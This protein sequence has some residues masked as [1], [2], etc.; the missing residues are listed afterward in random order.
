MITRDDII[1]VAEFLS[2]GLTESVI[3]EALH[4]LHEHESVYEVEDK[5]T[6][7]EKVLYSV[8]L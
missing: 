1:Q 7:I 3:N 5:F 4:R 8:Y 2:I 6:A